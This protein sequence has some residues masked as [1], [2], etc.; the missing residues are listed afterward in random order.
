MIEIVQMNFKNKLM[1][2]QTELKSPKNNSNDFGGYNYRTVEDILGAVKPLL[3]KYGCILTIQDYI[4][5]VAGRVYVKAVC[6]IADTESNDF[7]TSQAYARETL[8]K[9]KFDDAQLTG[10]ASSYARK[11]ALNGLFA[12]DNSDTID[13][14]DPKYSRSEMRS[15]A[16]EPI[17]AAPVEF[18]Q[19][20]PMENMP[21]A[22]KAV[23]K[24]VEAVESN[25]EEP[26]PVQEEVKEEFYR[27][28]TYVYIPEQDNFKKCRAGSKL[29][30]GA[31]EITREEFNEGVKA[32][33]EGKKAENMATVLKTDDTTDA[34]EVPFIEEP[35]E[36]TEPAEKPKKRT[37]RVRKVTPNE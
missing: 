7:A 1:H 20:Q 23:E 32:Y 17:V 27:K 13:P 34:E 26:V 22:E 15:D 10:S 6:H 14:D 18:K 8:E 36:P 37:R 16:K 30:P 19:A 31:V 25:A 5:E 11:Y 21:K 24:P 28:L 35:V 9:K 12:I 2:I 4:E 3:A 33:A 29:I